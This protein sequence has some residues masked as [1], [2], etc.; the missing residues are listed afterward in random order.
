MRLHDNGVQGTRD[1]VT[2]FGADFIDV[3]K[4][5][6][7]IQLSSG[8]TELVDIEMLN[9]IKNLVFASIPKT[10][11]EHVCNTA[12]ITPSQLEHIMPPKALSPLQEEMMSHHTCLHHLSWPKLISMVETG[13][14]QS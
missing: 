6:C 9:F 7:K 2:F 12:N 11:E 5:I 10:S 3:M 14:I 13:E 4:L 8:T 1:I